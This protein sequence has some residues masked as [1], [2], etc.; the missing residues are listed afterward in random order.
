MSVGLS[1]RDFIKLSGMLPLVKPMQA[2]LGDLHGPSPPSIL[3]LVLDTL[4]ARHM[5]LFGYRRQTT[6]NLERFAQRATVFHRCISGGNF[7]TPGTASL[8]TGTYPWSHRAF[9]INGTVADQVAGRN[10]FRLLRGRAYRLAYTHN[11]LADFLLWQFAQ[12]IDDH[13]PS[14]ELAINSD[15]FAELIFPADPIVARSAE[16][17]IENGDDSVHPSSLFLHRLHDRLASGLQTQARNALGDRFP[18]G[19]PRIHGMNF[20]LEDAID[21]IAGQLKS[22]P[23]PFLAYV[24]L[25]PPH[26]P[27][28]ARRDFVDL[29][30][31]AWT[32]SVKGPALF[33]QGVHPDRLRHERRMYDEYL[34]YT[35]AEFGRLFDFM[36]QEQILDDTLLVVTSDHGELFERG[37]LGH[38]TSSLYD[39]VIH[40][41]LLI[42]HPGQERRVDIRV[43]VSTVD[44]LPTLLRA[45]GEPIP[46]WVEGRVLPGFGPDRH[47]GARA[48]YAVEAKKSPKQGP[49]RTGGV[50]MV[51]GEYKLVRYFGHD[52]PLHDHYQLFHLLNDPEEMQDLYPKGLR[53]ARLMREELL[54]EMSSANQNLF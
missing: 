13:K 30:E 42:S 47:A 33:S 37:I 38:L 36:L 24:H 54:E 15:K 35:D 14:R 44:I 31:G 2:G 43:P 34:A 53:I 23:R 26:A 20:V 1:R 32:P 27:Y 3:I 40:V 29:F 50:A 21:W 22:L 39:P 4:S 12:D 46:G 10:L 6:P 41:P 5:S 16:W 52:E 9:H 48:V 51:K 18:R 7:T 49:L 17:V 45:L 19:V 11:T 28:A 25:I 8:L